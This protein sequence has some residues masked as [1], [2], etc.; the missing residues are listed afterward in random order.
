MKR[1][2]RTLALAFMA[3][4]V[5]CTS[6]SADLTGPGRALPEET[7]VVAAP[8]LIATLGELGGL[9]PPTLERIRAREGDSGAAAALAALERTRAGYM[10]RVAAGDT[11]GAYEWEGRLRLESAARI[12]AEL[13]NGAY[14]ALADSAVR[15]RDQLRTRLRDGSGAGTGPLQDRLQLAERLCA[16]A[17]A[18]ARAGR[19]PA[20]FDYAAQALETAGGWQGPPE[21]AARFGGGDADR[22]RLRD[23]SCDADGDGVPD[24]ERARDGTGRRSNG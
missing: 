20:A 17:A 10:V 4:M 1:K 3:G 7:A 5:G 6:A 18:A 14:T 24:R 9:L 15:A 8:E 19:M 21:W 11:A 12:A 16:A 2:H 23:G 13:G 22:I